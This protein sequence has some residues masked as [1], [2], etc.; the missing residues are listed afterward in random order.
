MKITIELTLEEIMLIRMGIA[1]S[2]NYAKE[3]AKAG[4]KTDP[5]VEYESRSTADLYKQLNNKLVEAVHSEGKKLFD[6]RKT[7]GVQ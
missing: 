1:R 3:S 4:H 2:Y 6:S 7:G 5:Y